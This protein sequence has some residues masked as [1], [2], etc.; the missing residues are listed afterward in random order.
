MPTLTYAD[1]QLAARAADW[2]HDLAGGIA[3][4]TDLDTDGLVGD[5]EFDGD[6]D[7][8]VMLAGVRFADLRASASEACDEVARVLAKTGLRNWHSNGS[9]VAL[10]VAYMIDDCGDA[11]DF[12]GQHWAAEFARSPAAYTADFV[13]YRALVG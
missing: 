7:P 11:D 12:D 5:L 4:M 13:A 8:Y 1:D 2:R 10:F 6:G 3:R 9:E